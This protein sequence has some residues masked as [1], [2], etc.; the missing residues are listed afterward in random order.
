M[1]KNILVELWV[2]IL[3]TKTFKNSENNDI[4]ELISQFNDYVIIKKQNKVIPK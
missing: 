3:I 4:M 2:T 1:T